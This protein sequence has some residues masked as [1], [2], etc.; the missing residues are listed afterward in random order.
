M[1]GLSAGQVLP[2]SNVYNPVAAFAGSQRAVEYPYGAYL[3][4]TNVNGSST[5]AP[6]NAYLEARIKL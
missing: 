4:G 3:S 2:Q 1:D 5:K 6:L